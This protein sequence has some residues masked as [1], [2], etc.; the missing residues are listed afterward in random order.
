MARE[1]QVSPPGYW[2]ENA[3]CANVP[4]DIDFFPESRSDETP[5]KAVCFSCEVMV[6]CLDYAV[7]NEIRHGIWG[8]MNERD[9]AKNIK[10]LQKAATER[11]LNKKYRRN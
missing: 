9:R 1:K 8:G 2:I 6:D 3:G 4:Q 7:T 5:A 10:Q 11:A